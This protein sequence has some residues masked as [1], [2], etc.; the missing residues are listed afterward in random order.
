MAKR[1]AA[2]LGLSILLVQTVLL[3]ELTQYVRLGAVSLSVLSFQI[4]QSTPQRHITPNGV[5]PVNQQPAES[6]RF[7]EDNDVLSAAG[8]MITPIRDKYAHSVLYI[9]SN[10]AGKFQGVTTIRYIEPGSCEKEVDTSDQR[11]VRF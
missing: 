10:K 5:T 8:W 2:L 11:E 1:L 9:I 6:F 3:H 4:L 7:Q